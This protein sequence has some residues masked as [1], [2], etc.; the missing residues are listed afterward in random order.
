VFKRWGLRSQG[1]DVSRWRGGLESDL[2]GR[3]TDRLG[4]LYEEV[5]EAP[6]AAE[7]PASS[8]AVAIKAA[9]A[10]L[11]PVRRPESVLPLIGAAALC[12]SAALALAAVVILGPPNLGPDVTVEKPAPAPRDVGR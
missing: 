11:H 7:P 5:P 9:R 12:A 8:V 4:A 10:Q 1:A 2:L 3:M 6:E